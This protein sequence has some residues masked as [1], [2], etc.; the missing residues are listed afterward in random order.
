VNWQVF[1]I[2]LAAISLFA[3]A[4]GQVVMALAM[5]QAARK[6]AK[7]VDEM[8][9]EIKPLIAKANRIADDAGRVVELA[10]IQV[11][12][13]DSLLAT[14]SARVDETLNVLQTVVVGPVKQGAAILA[15]VRAVLQALRS[16]QKRSSTPQDEEDPL[17][18]G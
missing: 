10:V 7:A 3:V 6:M 12:R 4:I 16:W 8:R 2:A 18:V 13:V 11:E 9:G 1:W 17:F 14:T 15:A 5:A